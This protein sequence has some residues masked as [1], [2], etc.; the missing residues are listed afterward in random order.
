MAYRQEMTNQPDEELFSSQLEVKDRDVSA[1]PTKRTELQEMTA[2]PRLT[3]INNDDGPE[4]PVVLPSESS[5][6]NEASVSKI[7]FDFSK[8]NAETK[9]EPAVV[10][11][12][13]GVSAIEF[14]LERYQPIEVIYQ[15]QRIKTFWAKD[16]LLGLQSRVTTINDVEGEEEY[17]KF[18]QDARK[19][20]RLQHEMILP[21]LEFG[22]TENHTAYLGANHP[23]GISL[24]DY[25]LE[26]GKLG[27]TKSI[28][29]M[30][31]ICDGL[32][33]AHADD[34]IHGGLC[35]NRIHV[36]DTISDVL[37]LQVS[38]FGVGR[39]EIEESC[40]NGKAPAE[41]GGPLFYRAPEAI[42]AKTA[43]S[44]SDIYSVGCIFFQCLTGRR[45]FPGW[46]VDEVKYMHQREAVPTLWKADPD[47]DHVL[48]TA[49]IIERCLNKDPDKRFGSINDLR[50][51]LL[52]LKEL[53][54]Y[55]GGTR[56]APAK[57]Q[58]RGKPDRASKLKDFTSALIFVYLI[59]AIVL[60][61]IFVMPL[62]P[63]T[64][65]LDLDMTILRS[66][67]ENRL[68]IMYGAISRA[69]LK[70]VNW[71]GIQSLSLF[72]VTIDK[73]PFSGLNLTELKVFEFTNSKG[74]SREALQGLIDP[75]RRGRTESHL[76]YFDFKKSDVK[77]EHLVP[78]QLLKEP[79]TI[80]VV[81]CDWSDADLRDLAALNLNIEFLDMRFNRKIT[82]AGLRSLRGK[83]IPYISAMGTGAEADPES[84]GMFGKVNP[85]SYV[86]TGFDDCRADIFT[87][88]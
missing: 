41:D 6:E 18:K 82:T 12:S 7:G 39:F 34:L 64:G 74:L 86:N 1:L 43:D 80:S 77:P 78:L 79:L 35:T 8:K 75:Q 2:G 51:S 58:T 25:L 44:R 14:P 24:T 69:N 88:Q 49:A 3:L 52:E 84:L 72:G 32:S 13:V 37:R 55:G 20:C 38:D 50:N 29:L 5:K 9:A 59:T 67:Y 11:K 83:G 45:V 15:S 87:D 53:L 16:K 42:F 28:E 17:K 40:T 71:K 61:C 23:D 48:E 47:G 76:T 57:E 65:G 73:D 68:D 85:G 26:F 36:V 60:A 4:S 56:S 66:D 54:L 27:S 70:K 10:R 81:D 30:I 31:Q 62:H 33:A 46:T 21:T 19:A 22:T 63:T